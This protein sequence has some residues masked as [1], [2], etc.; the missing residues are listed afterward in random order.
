MVN[1]MQPVRWGVLGTGMIAT[2]RVIPAMQHVALCD[3]AA[4]ASRNGERARAT[5]AQ[6]GIRKAYGDYQALLDDPEIEA[7]YIPLPNHIHVEWCERALRAGK[8]VLCEKPI[9]L[10]AA[11]AAPLLALRDQTGLLIEEAFAIRNHPQWA[12]MRDVLASGE[13]GGLVSVQATLAYSNL[14]AADIR[15]RPEVGGGALYDVGSYAVA[16]CRLIFNAEPTRVVAAMAKDASFGTDRL[17]SAILEFP[18]GHAAFT[19]ITQDGPIT[20]G[21][22]QH[23]GIVGARGWMRAEFPFA[24]SI[25]SPCR[26]LVGTELSI[27]STPVRDIAF[28]VLNQYALQGERF[29][30]LVRGQDAPRFPLELAIANMRVLDALR[31]SA[32][33]GAWADVDGAGP[34]ARR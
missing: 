24:H 3:I 32:R 8:H 6:L 27:G 21:T 14:N 2:L 29:S 17:T 18:Q 22:H 4:I 5:A 7:V 31:R 33:T 19:V 28:P 25:P 23:L 12:A 1:A 30:R 11:S 26:I 34:P 13:I 20:G 9:G 10:D 16:A 15:N